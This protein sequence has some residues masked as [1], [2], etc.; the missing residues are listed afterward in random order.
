MNIGDIYYANLGPGY[1]DRPVVVISN[2]RANTYSP[3]LTVIPLTKVLKKPRQPTHTVLD[4][5]RYNLQYN[6]M[7]LSESIQT[8]PKTAVRRYV[9]HLDDEAMRRV[10]ETV[11]LAI[12]AL[13]HI[14]S[15][16]LPGLVAT[17]KELD[18]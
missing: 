13:A 3:N 15:D 14:G 9:S 12:G 16:A 17:A 5:A 7:T 2:N 11:L 4:A 18:Q 10:S 8:I 1:E 6:S